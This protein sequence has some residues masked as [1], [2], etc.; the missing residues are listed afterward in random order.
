[1]I[2][3]SLGTFLIVSPT[4]LVAVLGIPD[5]ERLFYPDILGALLLG[6]GLALLIERVR[7]SGGLGLLGAVTINL[8]GGVVLAY[9]LFSNTLPLPFRES[10]DPV[11]YCSH[12]CGRKQL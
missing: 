2:N 8:A 7:G 9:W 4:R 3:L 1:M 6:I 5:S 11:G 10:P 12:S